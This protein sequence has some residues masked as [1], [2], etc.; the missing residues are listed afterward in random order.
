MEII[1]VPQFTGFETALQNAVP[2]PV[3]NKPADTKINWLPILVGIA[4]VGGIVY[5][6]YTIKKKAEDKF[7]EQTKQL[8]T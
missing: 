2:L 3:V 6:R 8:G 4:V 5:W 1:T 7:N